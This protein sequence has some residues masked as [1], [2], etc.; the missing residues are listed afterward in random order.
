MLYTFSV[1]PNM[2]SNKNYVK[3]FVL[4]NKTV[5]DLWSPAILCLIKLMLYYKIESC[6]SMCFM[7]MLMSGT[8]AK[9]CFFFFCYLT[10]FF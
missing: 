7:T 4:S 8:A 1:K 3:T 10:G 9:Q 6:V 5:W 2:T